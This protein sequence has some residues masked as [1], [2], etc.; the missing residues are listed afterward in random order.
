[1]VIAISLSKANRRRGEVQMHHTRDA[2][3]KQNPWIM[4]LRPRTGATTQSPFVRVSYKLKLRA[5]SEL[6]AGRRSESRAR[7]GSAVDAKCQISTSLFAVAAHEF[8]HSLGLSHS[9]VK[10][11]LMYPWYQGIKPNFV[12]PEDDRNGIQQMYGYKEKQLW[13]RIP[14]YGPVEPPPTTTTSTT[15][16]TTTRRP[17]HHHN[18]HN[19]HQDWPYRPTYTSRPP[20]RYPNRPHTPDRRYYNTPEEP[21]RRANPN[22][23]PT[24]ETTPRPTYYP[25]Y[26]T[27]KPD[28]PIYRPNNPKHDYPKKPYYPKKTTPR[29]T[30]A[31]P[32]DKPDTC[33]TSYD[34]VSLIREELFIFK[35]EIGARGRYDGYPIEISRMWSGLPKDLTHV[36]AVYERPDKKI[37]FFIGKEL[38]LFDSQY[39]MRGYPKPLVELGLPETLEKIDAAMVWGHNGKTYFY[40]GNM[41]W[42]FD[43]DEGRVELDYPRDMSMWKGVGYNIDSVFQWKDGKTYF[44][45]GKGYWKFNDLQMRVEHERQMPSAPF[46]MGCST[47][48]AGR[49]APFRALPTLRS[50]SSQHMHLANIYAILYSLSKNK[51]SSGIELGAGSLITLLIYIRDEIICYMSTMRAEPQATV[52]QLKEVFVQ[53]GEVTDV[54]LKY[55]KDG[56]FRNFG[57][58]G[59]KTEEEA[60]NA[61]EYFDGSCIN[62][63][64]ISVEICA[65][66]GDAKKPRAWSKYAP[67]S[68]AY[69]T[70]NKSSVE[71]QENEKNNSKKKRLNKNDKIKELLEKHKND[72]LFNEFIEAHVNEK[73]A[74]IKETLDKIKTNENDNSI[75]EDKTETQSHTEITQQIEPKKDTCK[76]ANKKISDLEYM[77]I[78]MKKTTSENS[79]NDT[80]DQRRIRNRPLFHIKISGLPFKCK[81]KDI[82]EF[83]RPLVPFS[84]RL[85]LGKEKKIAGFCFVGFRTEEELKKALFKDKLF[86]G[87]H[88][89]HIHKHEDKN[90]SETIKQEEIIKREKQQKDNDEESIGESGS[91][92]IRNLP[93][94]VTEDEVTRLFEKYGPIAEINMPIDK[95]LRQ[96]KGF[97]TVT[98][99]MP[100]HAVKAY[101][102]LDGTIFCG[103]MLHLL[104]AKAEKDKDD[105]ND[106]NPQPIYDTNG[107]QNF[108]ADT[109]SRIETTSCPTTI[110]YE[111]IASEPRKSFC[112]TKTTAAR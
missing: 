6:K 72:P 107:N 52:E 77:K 20:Y 31:P 27:S 85:P 64:K 89:I 79:E 56:K 63:M 5:G 51:D 45:K 68:T 70:M 92:F 55:T 13:A 84:I 1:M 47:E 36:D 53:K 94:V 59:Y 10:G 57:F 86:M 28:Y 15:T 61:K 74:W 40:S 21:P 97:A 7:T 80:G 3:A 33:D 93:Y 29:P 90:K 66:L 46:W 16:T 30:P 17:Y 101:T 87:K 43:E 32:S 44:F 49:R 42:K 25:R 39:L 100:E 81:K 69:K 99:M 65:N 54:Q 38:Y 19:H 41:Y 35:T 95:I 18:H 11:A 60:T 98:F 109:F 24:P 37:A 105:D 62:S 83:F 110:D 14:I 9:S 82:K 76:V 104:P 71:N 23:R 8:G 112:H 67:D 78:L 58:V 88:R 4:S 102:E 111:Q 48:R 2:Y 73:T 96:P 106:A 50:P 34:A 91:I 12:L 103:R 22:P 75:E 26:P 108:V